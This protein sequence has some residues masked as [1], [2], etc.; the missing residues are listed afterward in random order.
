MFWFGS[1]RILLSCCWGTNRRRWFRLIVLVCPCRFWGCPWSCPSTRICPFSL[2]VRTRWTSCPWTPPSSSRSGCVTH[3]CP[4]RWSYCWRFLRRCCRRSTF[5]PPWAYL[6]PSCLRSRTLM[7][8]SYVPCHASCVPW[9]LL[10]RFLPSSRWSWPCCPPKSQ[11]GCGYCWWD[12]FL[13][14]FYG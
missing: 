11:Y 6:L 10:R 12:C 13:W 8:S 2:A 14:C 3:I 9:S 1:D 5:P 7:A 4:S